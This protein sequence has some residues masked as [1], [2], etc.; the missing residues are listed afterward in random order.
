ME[1][2]TRKYLRTAI[3]EALNAEDDIAVI[4]LCSLLKGQKPEMPRIPMPALPSAK[5][6]IEGPAHDYHFWVLYIRNEFIPFMN[7]HG[8]DKF[9]SHELLSWIERNSKTLFTTGDMQICKKGREC[10]RNIVSNALTHL[11][12]QGI[13]DTIPFGKEY[14][15]CKQNR[16]TQLLTNETHL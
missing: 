16:F 9:T 8:R 14:T 12:T 7:T 3:S 13:F 10:W 2:C 4:E 15:I 6:I 1:S 5:E 11:K